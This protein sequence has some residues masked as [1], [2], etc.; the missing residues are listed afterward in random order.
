ML[1]MVRLSRERD[2][3]NVAGQ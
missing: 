1:M 2:S 3:Y